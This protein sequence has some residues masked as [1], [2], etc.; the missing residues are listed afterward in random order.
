[1]RGVLCARIADRRAIL[2]RAGS[3][4]CG[5]K[6]GGEQ[7]GG[8]IPGFVRGHVGPSAGDEPVRADAGDAFVAAADEARDDCG[9]GVAGCATGGGG[10]ERVRGVEERGGAVGGGGGGGGACAGGWSARVYRGAGVCGHGAR[11][12]GQTEAGGDA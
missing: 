11:R 6:R 2:Q 7:R 12:Q 10:D 5:I 3:V 4:V 8:W 9:G 1:M